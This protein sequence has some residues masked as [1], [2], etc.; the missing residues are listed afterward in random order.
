MSK[1]SVIAKIPC[2]EGKR[3]ELVAAFADYF[4]QVEGED[5]T[6]VYAVSTDNGD[7]NV[8]WVYELYSGDDAL[9]AHS[10][11]DAFQAFAGK[12]GGLLAGAPELHLCRPVHAKGHDL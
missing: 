6:L 11:S 8:V 3:D 4:P 1:V 9:Q 12:L 10:S 2:Q 7:P 5:G